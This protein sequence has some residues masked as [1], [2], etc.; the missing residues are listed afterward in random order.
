MQSR[1]GFKGQT[2]GGKFP[3]FKKGDKKPGKKEDP[4]GKKMPPW[5][6]GKKK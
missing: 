5:L 2:K 6:K 4:K 1:A 3:A